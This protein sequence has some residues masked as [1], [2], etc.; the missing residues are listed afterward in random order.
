M[1]EAPELELDRGRGA[2]ELDHAHLALGEAVLQLV[3]NLG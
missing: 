1:E 2:E 3:L